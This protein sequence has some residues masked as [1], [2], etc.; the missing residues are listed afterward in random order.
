MF[1]SN[2]PN[3]EVLI[4]L[5]INEFLSLATICRHLGLFSVYH[6]RM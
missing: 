6:Q 1:V 3:T 5:D 4:T 2:I